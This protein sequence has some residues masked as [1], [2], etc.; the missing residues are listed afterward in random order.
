MSGLIR[1][2]LPYLTVAVIMVLVMLAAYAAVHFVPN[3]TSRELWSENPTSIVF[4]ATT[5]VGSSGSIK[6]SF[7]CAPPVS[8]VNLKTTVNDPTRIRLTLSQY[9]I[10]SCGPSF[11]TIT[12][13][14]K[15]LVSACAG[16]YTGTIE[17]LKDEY[18]IIPTGLTVTITVE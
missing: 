16:S 12:I 17:I 2:F 14:A 13:T 5:G 1:T 7:K 6:D 10:V 11:T 3:T 4:A 15:C 18:T 9:N 8:N